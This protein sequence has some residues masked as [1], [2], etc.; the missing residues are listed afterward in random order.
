MDEFSQLEYQYSNIGLTAQAMKDALKCLVVLITEQ[1]FANGDLPFA[2]KNPDGHWSIL[3]MI[4][5]RK[6][7]SVWKIFMNTTLLNIKEYSERRHPVIIWFFSLWICRRIKIH[8]VSLRHYTIPKGIKSNGKII[9]MA[10]PLIT[11]PELFDLAPGKSCDRSFYLKK[12]MTFIGLIT[13]IRVGGTE[14]DWFY[15]KTIP[16]FIST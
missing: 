12:V 9:Y 5:L 15:G 7:A 14:L 2:K 10:T 3:L 11:K 1:T 4:T 16:D 8:Q 6:I 13:V